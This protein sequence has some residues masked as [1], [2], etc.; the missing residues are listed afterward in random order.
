MHQ[1]L[2]SAA[3]LSTPR[4]AKAEAPSEALHQRDLSVPGSPSLARKAR[5]LLPSTGPAPTRLLI[6]LHGRGE[7][8]SER[9]GLKAWSEL[10]GLSQSY[11][12]LQHAPVEPVLKTPRI[13]AKRLKRINADL[14]SR[15]FTGMAIV[16]PVTPNPAD[17]ANRDVMLDRYAAWLVS[18]LVPAVRAEVPSLGTQ[19]GL[20]GCSMGGYVGLEVFKRKAQAFSS[21][22]IVQSAIGTWR[23]PGYTQAISQALKQGARV[24]LHLQTST[25]D[26]FREATELLSI[27]LRERGIDNDLDVIAGA[28][29]QL[30][31]RQI[32]SLEMLLWHDRN[33]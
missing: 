30:W 2:A 33:L 25:R 28:H 27:Q 16:C 5:L 31:L 12:R 23:V 3:P 7:T 9:M 22:G 1:A 15:P 19:V 8:S 11:Q 29:D 10:Y 17:A 21:F 24:K 32:G 4:L 13:A 6:L 26:P 14:E 18:E 20:D